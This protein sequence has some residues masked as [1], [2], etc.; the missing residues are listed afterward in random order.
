MKLLGPL[1]VALI[2]SLPRL[3]LAHSA[4]TPQQINEVALEQRVNEKISPELVFRDETGREVTLRAYL[5]GRPV[6]LVPLYYHCPDLC[7]LVLKNLADTLKRLPFQAG[8][9]FEVVAFSIDPRETPKLAREAKRRIASELGRGDAGNGWHFLSG[10]QRSIAALAHAIGLRYV[11]D[12]VDDEYAHASGIVVLTGDGR[13]ARYF[14][15]ITYKP[16]DLRLA[17]VDASASR[18]G[19]PVDQFLLRCFHWDPKTGKYTLDILKILQVLGAATLVGIAAV[20]GIMIREERRRRVAPP[21]AK[22]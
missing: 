9:D 3:G 4:L 18:I 1:V 6:L 16:D 5:I 10:G 19:T 20:I 13:I 11:Y 2:V 8:K 22:S 17:L 12:A 7:P 21:S 15:G 14:Y